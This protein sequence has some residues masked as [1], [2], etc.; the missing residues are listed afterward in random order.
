MPIELRWLVSTAASSLHAAEAIV[1]GAALVDRRTAAA[2]AEEAGGLATDLDALALVPDRFFEH[3]AALSAKIDSPTEWARTVMAK[4]LGRSDQV[5]SHQPLARRFIA[6][7]AAFA[8]ENPHALEELELRS[9]PLREQWEARG[10]GL[11]ATVA[12]RTDP[13]LIVAAADA[14]LVQPVLGGGGA[15]HCYYNSVRI[16]AVLANPIA[17]LPEV[18]RLAWLLAQLNLDLPMFHG[19]LHRDRLLRVWPLAMIP[20]VLA[21]AQEVELARY[22]QPTLDAALAAWVGVGGA[23]MSETLSQWWETYESTTPTWPAALGALD[24]MLGK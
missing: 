13:D 21:A 19:H 15:S 8:R 23:A 7:Q 17:E 5:D 1:R 14:V 4:L 22:D 20:P 18:V 12:Q 2:L 10:P 3:A 24:Q 6:L 9:Q 11:L 16:E